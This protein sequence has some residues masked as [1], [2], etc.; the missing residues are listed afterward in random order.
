MDT[1]SSFSSAALPELFSKM[2]LA[3]SSDDFERVLMLS[4]EILTSSPTDARAARQ[5]ITALIKLDRYAEALA[6][7]HGSSFLED[8]ETLLERGFCLYKVGK[9]EEAKQVLDGGSGRA[10]DHVRAQI[11]MP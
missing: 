5:K 11:V 8:T 10:V 4:N 7:I 2:T 9:C 3:A 6:F 1:S